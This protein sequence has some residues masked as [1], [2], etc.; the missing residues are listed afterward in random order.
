MRPLIAAAIITYSSSLSADAA[1]WK[2]GQMGDRTFA[3]VEA[4]RPSN[5]VAA[6]FALE[7][8]LD[9]RDWYWRAALLFGSDVRVRTISIRF[10]D[11]PAQTAFGK[12]GKTVPL[13]TISL[14]KLGATKQI[15]VDVDAQSA[16]L[17]YAF[18]LSGGG[19]LD[20]VCSR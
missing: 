2:I 9:G 14:P 18:K 20:S 17:S 1:E 7:C 3:L 16:R 10:D 6:Q 8:V 11:E 19:L 4:E 5:G 13:D 15:S 12:F